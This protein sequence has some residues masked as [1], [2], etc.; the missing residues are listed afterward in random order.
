[1]QRPEKALTESLF[2]ETACAAEP[3]PGAS[4]LVCRRSPEQTFSRAEKLFS[5][6]DDIYIHT[7]ARGKNLNMKAMS[8]AETIN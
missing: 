5:R 7:A 8:I 4:G 1:M 3:I 2:A 6:A